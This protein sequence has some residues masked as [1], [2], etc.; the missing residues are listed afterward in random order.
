MSSILF[1][2]DSIVGTFIFSSL[3]VEDT[4]FQHASHGASILMTLH[5]FSIPL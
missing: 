4:Y 5:N 1:L 3:F 2:V